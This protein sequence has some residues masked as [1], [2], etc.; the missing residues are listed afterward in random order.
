MKISARGVPSFR[1]EELDKFEIPIKVVR[2]PPPLIQISP[3]PSVNERQL[4]GQLRVLR[5]EKQ[6]ARV[7]K[8]QVTRTSIA[9]FL[10]PEY[11]VELRN[12]L[13]L[14]LQLKNASASGNWDP[15]QHTRLAVAANL[16]F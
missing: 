15:I 4:S 7:C 10:Q 5:H 9:A 13:L 14:A 3:D 6:E 1:L 2:T 16:R 12:L 11:P 8:L